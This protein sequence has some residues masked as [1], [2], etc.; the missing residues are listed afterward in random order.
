VNVMGKKAKNFIRKVFETIKRPEMQIL[1]GQLAFFFVLSLIPLIALVGSLASLFSLS[2]ESLTELISSS[3]PK[4]VGN[5]L[6]PIITGKD[7]S[8]NM[9]IFFGSAFL[10]ASN[11]MKSMIIAA[12]MI[13]KVDDIDHLRVRIK[14]IIMTFILVF[15]LLFV[16]IVPAFGDLI[17]KLLRSLALDQRIIKFIY[18]L[19]QILKY[20]LSLFLIHFNIKLLYT[21]APDKS[22]SSSKMNYGAWFTTIMWIL[23]TEVYSIYVEVFSKY[24]LFYGSISN[25]LIL[26]LWVYLLAYI[27]TLGMALNSSTYEE[28]EEIKE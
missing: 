15:L 3:F 16:I 25:I 10:L 23:V 14:S 28:K 27:M 9:F 1:P 7:P 6:L 12:D 22:I 21:I 20:P 2:M 26:L 19:Y 24:D 13:Y 4:E 17:F 5:L 11:G 18:R 8:F